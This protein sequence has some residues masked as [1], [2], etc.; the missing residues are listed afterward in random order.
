LLW[1]KQSYLQPMKTLNQRLAAEVRVDADEV[2]GVEEALQAR[3]TCYQPLKKCSYR[4][5]LLQRTVWLY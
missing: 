5:I 3:W 4:L 2:G 1:L